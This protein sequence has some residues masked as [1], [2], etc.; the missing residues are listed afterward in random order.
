MSQVT[1]QKKDKIVKDYIE[2]MS[3]MMRYNYPQLSKQELE[4][5][6]CYSI[7]KR[8][9]LEPAQIYN[10][11]KGKT[12]DM[13]LYEIVNYIMER[14][15]IMTA[16]GV[17]FHNHGKVPNPLSKLFQTFLDKRQLDKDKMFTFP[18]GSEEY[19]RYNLFQLLDKLDANGYQYSP[20]GL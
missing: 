14:E 7:E 6:I 9:R 20:A 16:Y 18:P 4:D 17:L 19:E 10:N 5:A 3:R 11:Y 2:V 8:Y 1:P 13:T 12:V 15:P